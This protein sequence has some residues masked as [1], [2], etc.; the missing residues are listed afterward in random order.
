[1]ASGLEQG[2]VSRSNCAAS[3]LRRNHGTFM[4]CCNSRSLGLLLDSSKV[5]GLFDFGGRDRIVRRWGA[6]IFCYSGRFGRFSTMCLGTI[7]CRGSSMRL[8]NSAF[9][10]TC[11]RRYGATRSLLRALSRVYRLYSFV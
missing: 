6:C 8:R 10:R 7:C 1:M 4:C 9:Y 2:T 11:G 3:L 5:H